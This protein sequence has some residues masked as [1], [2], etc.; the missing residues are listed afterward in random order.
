MTN[1]PNRCINALNYYS[2][3]NDTYGNL[4]KDNKAYNTLNTLLFNDIVSERAR[5]KEGKLLN[6]NFLNEDSVKEIPALCADLITAAFL[7]GK[8]APAQTVFRVS[9]HS[10]VE[11]M[12]KAGKTL[13][14]T[15]ASKNQYL[16]TYAD[17]D[18]LVLLE[19]FIP[20]N[21]PRADFEFL[22][23]NY[24]RLEE[25]EVLLPPWLLTTFE[26]CE[27][28][29]EELQIKD[30]FGK[31]P[32]AKYHVIA[33]GALEPPEFDISYMIE[34]PT[35]EPGKRVFNALLSGIEP[36]LNDIRKYLIW[37]KALQ[38]EIVTKSS[39]QSLSAVYDESQSTVRYITGDVLDNLF[40][41]SK[42]RDWI[43]ALLGANNN[44]VLSRRVEDLPDERVTHTI[45]TFLLGNW[46]RDKLRLDFHKLPR[47]F[48]Q[49]N[50]CGDSFPFF[51]TVVCLGHD[52][53]YLF[54]NDND[55]EIINVLASD[56]TSNY[57]ELRKLLKL[58]NDRLL[59]E[60]TRNNLERCGLNSAECNWA[61]RSIRMAKKYY[62][63]RL[64]NHGCVDHG[65]AGAIILFD[66]LQE[67]ATKSIHNEP[68]SR[69]DKFGKSGFVAANTQNNRFLAC[70]ILVTLAIARHN[71][72][73]VDGNRLDDI[74]YNPLQIYQNAGLEELIVHGDINKLSIHEPL[75]QL[76]YFLDYLDTIDPF[77]AFYLRNNQ[78]SRDCNAWKEF[79]TQR[80]Q[81]GFCRGKAG[82]CHQIRFFFDIEGCALD[83]IP[84]IS[85]FKKTVHDMA[86]WLQI[87]QEPVGTT[88]MINL[89]L[90]VTERKKSLNNAYGVSDEEMLDLCFYQGIP[91]S[92]RPGT[93]FQSPNAYQSFNL[94][95]MEGLAGEKVRIGKEHQH[96][97]S[98]YVRSW[99]MTLTVFRNIFSAMCKCRYALS[100]EDNI[101][102]R[103]DRRLNAEQMCKKNHTI[104]FTSTTKSEYLSKFL[105]GKNEPVVETLR[106]TEQ[107]PTFDFQQILKEDYAFTDE[108]E[109]LLPPFVKFISPFELPLKSA[110]KASDNN[111][112]YLSLTLEKMDF[113]LDNRDK[114]TLFHQLDRLKD[115]AAETL[116]FFISDNTAIITMKED[117]CPSYI[118]WKKAFQEL[119]A[120]E[121]YEIYNNII[122][123]TEEPW[124]STI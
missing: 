40:D 23:P 31:P 39:F 29:E 92:S 55:L 116:D 5:V 63:F 93:F 115:K 27:L 97:N 124:G 52:I 91:D 41:S 102:H 22:I 87:K 104:A 112:L 113:P 18:G 10:D 75:D 9:R 51:W 85:K 49:N 30:C 120:L 122:P 84:T 90:P 12:K 103:M 54:E 94:L 45:T 114:N 80:I 74:N 25:A 15:S 17:K 38:T 68:I 60:L 42:G 1:I 8:G 21:T 111:P 48:S 20:D 107:I 4:P 71:M 28:S 86:G 98:I 95:M 64:L 62:N 37:K 57:Q 61:E 24:A 14:F 77:K 66:I 73:V 83:S 13:T 56:T 70:S 6:L 32:I 58:S 96:P 118:A 34:M 69:H 44:T 11:A 33:E 72:W 3:Q 53:G 105:E 123:I 76:L 50:K 89:Y 19:I 65:I 35:A 99:R 2:G 26:E 16:N 121:F 101:L 109:V 106:L 78:N 82:G 79:I 100:D 110:S 119:V 117:D 81:I 88:Q 36:E 108:A 46:L 43:K 67:M 47:I 7:G 59:L